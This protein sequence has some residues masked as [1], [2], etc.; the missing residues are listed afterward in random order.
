MKNPTVSKRVPMSSFAILMLV[1]SAIEA[2]T[3]VNEDGLIF[4]V[5]CGFVCRDTET[6]EELMQACKDHLEMHNG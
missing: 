1:G 4:C 6:H 2:E 5:P 3:G